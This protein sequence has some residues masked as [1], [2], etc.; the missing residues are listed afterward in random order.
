[1]DFNT[2]LRG[3]PFG[4]KL[5]KKLHKEGKTCEGAMYVQAT[6]TKVMATA[7]NC[8]AALFNMLILITTLKS[9]V[10]ITEA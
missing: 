7:T 1:M 2:A 5:A 4:T 6:S 10:T 3:R 9:Q 8:K